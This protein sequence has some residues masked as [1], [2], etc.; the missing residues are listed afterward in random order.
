MA[1]DLH[2]KLIQDYK[3]VAGSRFPEWVFLDI[4]GK[5]VPGSK[6]LEAKDGCE[7]KHILGWSH[8]A[9]SCPDHNQKF[10]LKDKNSGEPLKHIY[11]I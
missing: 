2:F 6:P 5:E 8:I 7:I 3:N 4:D 10:L 9:C 11:Y 1:C